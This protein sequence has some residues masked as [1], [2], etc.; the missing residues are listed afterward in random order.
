M[1]KSSLMFPLE[2]LGRHVIYVFQYEREIVK[3]QEVKQD[4]IQ[5]EFTPLILRIISII[6]M[7]RPRAI[8]IDANI[9]KL[10]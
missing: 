3:R 5:I 10:R 9:K 8:A 2:S 6:D 7:T 4:K 1:D